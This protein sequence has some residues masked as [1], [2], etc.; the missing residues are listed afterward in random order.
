MQILTSS[1]AEAP[2]NSHEI[3]R[4]L[5]DYKQTKK[6]ARELR[7]EML[8]VAVDELGIDQKAAQQ[9]NLETFLEGY[10]L[11]Q[12][13]IDAC[14]T[15]SN[16]QISALLRHSQQTKKDARALRRELLKVAVEELGMEQ[17]EAL[18]ANLEVF[19]DGYLLG[20]GMLQAWRKC[21]T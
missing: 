14:R 16:N 8:R 21:G 12:D 4:L 11:G 2:M 6:D 13:R 10:L 17:S 3:A 7:V 1:A 9:T 15:L 18:Q 5:R 19:T 20:Q